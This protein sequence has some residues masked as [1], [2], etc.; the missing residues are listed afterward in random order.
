MSALKKQEG[1]KHYVMPIQPIEYIT[2]NKLPYIEG[3]IIKYA[4]RHRN[5]NGAE[6]IKKIIHYCELLLELEYG[7]KQGIIGLM[8]RVTIDDDI[9]EADLE[10]INDF[11]QAISERD[12]T[13]L[14]EV[15][16]LAKQRLETTYE[17]YDVNL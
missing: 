7:A 1:G 12:A 6:D 4:T 14:D 3:N 17:E 10:L 8:I 16:Y 9:H 5:K 11:A 2:K 13:L 15:V